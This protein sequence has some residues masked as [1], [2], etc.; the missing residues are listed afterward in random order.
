MD[1]AFN[2]SISLDNMSD[3]GGHVLFVHISERDV[4]IKYDM[5]TKKAF[6]AQRKNIFKLMVS[7]LNFEIILQSEMRL[8]Q[9]L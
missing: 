3:T 6:N 7:R 5:L 2:I 9:L 8:M 1:I 4:F